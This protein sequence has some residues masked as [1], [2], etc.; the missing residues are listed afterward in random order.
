GQERR[1]E[2]GLGAVVAPTLTAF[3][4]TARAAVPALSARATIPVATIA[5]WAAIVTAAAITIT[6]AS[7]AT[8]MT[9]ATAFASRTTLATLT[10][11][12][13][14]AGVGQLFAGLLVD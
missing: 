2:L 4:F 13:R 11:F 9:V 12:A 6:A 3:T 1:G 8:K 10:R 5:A 14:G 7:A